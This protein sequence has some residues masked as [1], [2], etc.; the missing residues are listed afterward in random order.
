MGKLSA[1]YMGLSLRSPYVASSSGLTEKVASLVALDQAGIGAVVL[2]SLFEEQIMGLTNSIWEGESDPE[3]YEAIRSYTEAR[4]VGAYLRTIREAK[5]SCGVPIIASISCTVRG[6]WEE[7]AKQMAEAGADALEV[8]IFLLPT[9][10]TRPAADYERLYVDTVK[11]VVEQVSI[12]VSVKLARMFT[13]PLH[14]MSQL[15]YVGAKGCIL[16]NRYYEPDIDLTSMKLVPGEMFSTPGEL[17]QTLRWVAMGTSQ[18]EPLDIG[19][20]TGVH[21]AH[22]AAKAILAG[23]C[24]TQVCTA[25][26]QHGPA[27]VSQLNDELERLIEEHGFS[28]LAAMR[29]RMDYAHAGN[30]AMFERSQFMIY[31]AS[32]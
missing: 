29:G 31:Y 25:L 24:V 8:N 21:T 20:S 26:Y 1:Q 2:K 16:F 6:R 11:R 28:N 18:I 13:N 10:A 27:Y 14:M 15:S 12:P 30:P 9:D 3:S 5:A 23:A 19:V 32:R 17:I 4:E 22:E 7:F